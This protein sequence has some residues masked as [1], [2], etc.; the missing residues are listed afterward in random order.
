MHQCL[1][2]QEGTVGP[3]PVHPE[4]RGCD[5]GPGSAS[6]GGQALP[7]GARGNPDVL[8]SWEARGA[9]QQQASR[10]PGGGTAYP[11]SPAS[12][13]SPTVSPFLLHTGS[14]GQ[15]G[16][17]YYF[18]SQAQ[19]AMI[20][21]Q[22]LQA[23]EVFGWEMKGE[24]AQHGYFRNLPLDP[25]ICMAAVQFFGLRSELVLHKAKQPVVSCWQRWQ[26]AIWAPGAGRQ[27]ADLHP[28]LASNHLGNG[29]CLQRGG[30]RR[31]WDAQGLLGLLQ[32]THHL[33]AYERRSRRPAAAEG[34]KAEGK[35]WLLSTARGAMASEPEWVEEAMRTMQTAFGT[36]RCDPVLHGLDCPRRRLSG[37]G[38]R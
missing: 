3:P 13:A 1:G 24:G 5:E 10:A 6:E 2:E 26:V 18:S 23:S 29:V 30:S 25:L 19:E 17:R 37:Q 9:A 34:D 16:G 14:P 35:W 12:L 21:C 33:F 11:A 38:R 22:N 4:M 36:G 31:W 28:T 7:L 8:M 15:G 32:D 27:L 20:D